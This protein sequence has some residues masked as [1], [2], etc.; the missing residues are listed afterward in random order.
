MFA[1]VREIS[2]SVYKLTVGL[3]AVCLMFGKYGLKNPVGLYVKRFA[4]SV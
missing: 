3:L 2:T 1:V 4:L